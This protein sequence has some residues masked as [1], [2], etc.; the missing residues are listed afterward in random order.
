MERTMAAVHRDLFE[1]EDSAGEEEAEPEAEKLDASD[2]RSR[3]SAHERGRL[4]LAD[5]I[6]KLEAANDAKRD[7]TL[8]GEARA[9]DRPLNSLLEE[10]LE[11]ER[12]GKPIPIPTA[13]VSESLEQ[14]IKRRIL[15]FDFQDLVRRRPDDI[16]TGGA[17]RGAERY[18][19]DDSK[20]EKGW[21][22]SMRRII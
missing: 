5:E 16:A 2:P 1:D 22:R 13:E 17:R 15:A 20:S 12:A 6:R 11:F 9:A 4:A 8:S 18:E 3:K 21:R 10:D 7:W 14:L 19:V